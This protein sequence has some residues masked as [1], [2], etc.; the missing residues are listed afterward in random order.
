MAE[1]GR[2]I[3]L[4]MFADADAGTALGQQR[5]QCGLAHLKRLAAQI[6]AVQLDQIEGIQDDV[7]ITATGMQLVEPK[8]GLNL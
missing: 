8:R 5:G 6:V 7:A 4:D 3:R 1:Y 2:P